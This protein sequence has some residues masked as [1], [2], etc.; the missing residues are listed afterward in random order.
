MPSPSLSQRVIS[1]TEDDY[2]STSINAILNSNV[3]YSRLFMREQKPWTGKQI[4]IPIQ[5]AK[6]TTGGSFSGTGD[7]QTALQDTRR[8]QTFRHTMFY[9]NVTLA[10]GEVSLNKSEGE[11]LNLMYIT[12][13]EAVEAGSDSIGDQFYD[14]GYGDDFIGL[15]AIV[16]NGTATSTYGDL[17]RSQYPMLNSA[18]NAANNGTLDFSLM[19][20]VMTGASAASS[21]R[22]RPSIILCDE[23]AWGLL[24]SKYT[25]AVTATYDALSR[26]EI[27]TYSKP[28]VAMDPGQSL[29]TGQQGFECLRWAGIP[30]L[31]D[32]KCDPNTQFFINEEYLHWYNLPGDDLKSYQIPNN[33]SVDSVYTEFKPNYPLQ[34][35]GFV[36]PSGQYSKIGQFIA[37]GN[38]ICGQTRRMGKATGILQA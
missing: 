8:L 26:A 31:V 35:T 34:W 19:R 2:A 24:E 37:L 3:F 18:I 33:G 36:K 17:N 28:G 4:Q 5:I 29:A 16:D 22:Q 1:S 38:M 13:Q 25:P 14:M 6:P 7:F 32:E 10:G 11:V 20:T 9:Q 12:M 21:K 23:T 27:T 15:G 30:I